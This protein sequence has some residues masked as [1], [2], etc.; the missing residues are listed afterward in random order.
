[1]KLYT[2]AA[3]IRGEINHKLWLFI[4]NVKFAG[5]SKSHLYLNSSVVL[6]GM[7]D[8]EQVELVIQGECASSADNCG[9]YYKGLH[10]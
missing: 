3:I 2:L 8:L 6:L 1:M 4:L 5:V 10:V 7:L 9:Q